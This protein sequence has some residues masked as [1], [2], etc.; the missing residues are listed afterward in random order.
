MSARP[1]VK[2]MHVL[3]ERLGLGLVAARDFVLFALMFWF[4]KGFLDL[5]QMKIDGHVSSTMSHANGTKIVFMLNFSQFIGLT[6]FGLALFSVSALQQ[7]KSTRTILTIGYASALV[8]NSFIWIVSG[9][10]VFTTAGVPY[11]LWVAHIC[12]ALILASI[13]FSSADVRSFQPSSVSEAKSLGKQFPIIFINFIFGLF[14]HVWAAFFPDRF[15]Q[16]Y[17]IDDI[18]GKNNVL[19][20]ISLP[21]LKGAAVNQIS[22]AFIAAAI[23]FSNDGRAAY[24]YSRMSA[25]YWIVFAV[26]TGSVCPTHLVLGEARAQYVQSRLFNSVVGFVFGA[27]AIVPVM[28]RD[29]LIAKNVFSGKA[30]PLK[31]D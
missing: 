7:S 29:N 14:M 30:K 2:P 12:S 23:L 1:A 10:N 8:Y 6:F 28:F 15:T 18:I 26:M 5:H 11:D 9:P 3:P 20:Q 21:M 4:P 17:G 31:R 24:A 19:F 13:C 27:I 16:S 22:F 25:M